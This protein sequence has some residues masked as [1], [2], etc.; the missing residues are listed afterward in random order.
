MANLKKSSEGWFLLEL[1]VK[2]LR[3]IYLAW[4]GIT[5]VMLVLFS[6][7]H[8]EVASFIMQ[9]PLRYLFDSLWGN[10]V[11]LGLGVLL[12]IAAFM[13]LWEL[14]SLVLISVSRGSR[15]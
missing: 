14:I 1:V 2:L 10:G 15:R 3:F 13:E 5:L 12:C 11:L 7:P 4:G 9:T 6:P 8:L